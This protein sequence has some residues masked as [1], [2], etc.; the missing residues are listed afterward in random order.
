MNKTVPKSF[1]QKPALEIVKDFLGKDLVYNS[2]KGTV[3]GT[4]TDVEAYPAGVDEVSHGNK[5]TKRTEILYK[6][7][8]YAYV[9]LIY[10]IHH[11]FAIVV[12]KKNIPEVVFI[13][14]VIPKLGIGIMKENF[15]KEVKKDLDLT[16]SPGN[17]C[18][19]FGITLDLYGENI[20]GNKL[21]LEET[22]LQIK[23]KGIKQ[24]NRV[25]INKKL[26]GSKSKFRY[27]ITPESI[28]KTLFI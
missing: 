12:N 23:E 3:S 15:G 18:K 20:P 13:R 27:Y 8:G 1:F 21:W 11:Q 2:P 25:G 5:R 4:I 9:Y 22:D 24:K 6:E 28:P 17:L 10:G 26:K 14:A 7:G 16:K 19:S